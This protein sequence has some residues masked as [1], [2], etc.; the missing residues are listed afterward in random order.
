MSVEGARASLPGGPTVLFAVLGTLVLGVLA[1]GTAWGRGPGRRLV[2]G[3]WMGAGAGLVMGV[4]AMIVSAL[5]L[6]LPWYAPPRVFAT[7]VMGQDALA[8]ILGFKLV[9]FVVGLM[10]VLVL[11]GLLGILFAWLLRRYEPGRIVLAGLLYGVAIW[12]L[13]QYVVL[14]LLFPLVA[15][16][17]FPPLWYAITFAV[18]GLTLGLLFASRPYSRRNLPSGSNSPANVRKQEE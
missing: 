14:P 7:M 12:A 13:L 1:V 4:I 5:V 2:D 9:P 17:G 18:Y 10:V 11:T 16:K 6:F 8:N 15:E 3:L